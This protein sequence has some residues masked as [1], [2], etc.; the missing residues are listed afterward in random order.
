MH[1]SEAAFKVQGGL[2]ACRE[3]AARERLVMLKSNDVGAYLKL[4]QSAKNSRLSQ[5]LT[6]TDT[7]LN[8]L[9]ARLKL[10]P[11]LHSS[12]SAAAPDGGCDGKLSTTLCCSKSSSGGSACKGRLHL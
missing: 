9:A 2:H 6:Q 11:G 5:L 12:Q 4:V 1:E 10:K 3:A 7:C 8:K